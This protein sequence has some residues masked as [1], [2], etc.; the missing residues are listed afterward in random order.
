M[1]Q[2]TVPALLSALPIFV[3]A[4][5]LIPPDVLAQGG[6]E[7]KLAAESSLIG[8]IYKLVMAVFGTLVLW[9]GL[10]LN[11][12]VTH[13]VVGFGQL[14]TTSGLGITVDSLWVI[15]RD[16]FNLT[17]IFGLVLIGLKLIFNSDD[18]TTKKLLINLIIAAL[19]VNF[20][21]FI[22]KVV[23]DFSNI[24][25]VELVKAFPTTPVT[26]GGVATQNYDI[27]GSFV[28]LLGVQTLF[29]TRQTTDSSGASWAYVFMTMILFCIAAFVFAAGGILL[30][31]RFVVLNFCLILSPLMFLG[32]VF[33][34]LMSVSSK[35][36]HFFLS[37]AF[38]APV[39]I[40]MIYF[41]H[42]ILT[43][44]KAT[45]DAAGGGSANLST[46]FQNSAATT[47][48]ANVTASIYSAVIP[49]VL[50]SIFL[51]AAIVIS[52]KMG[53][54]GAT[55]AISMG[56]S[57]RARA[58]K[59][60]IGGSMYMGAK[61]AQNTV[62]WGARYALNSKLGSNFKSSAAKGGIIGT[63]AMA[64]VRATNATANASFDPRNVKALGLDKIG[65]AGVKGGYDN[66][67]KRKEK[68]FEERLKL[69]GE[70]DLDSDEGKEKLQTIANAD[71][72]T[73]DK[74]GN[75]IPQSNLN[76][77]VV[78]REAAEK[79]KKQIE[80]GQAALLKRQ[81]TISATFDEKISD[82]EKQLTE[83]QTNGM[84][85]TTQETL[86]AQI[87]E[88]KDA[89][90]ATL[91]PT[92]DQLTKTNAALNTAAH[93]LEK[94]ADAEKKETEKVKPSIQ[95]ERHLDYINSE[96]RAGEYWRSLS[97][98]VLSTGSGGIGGV[99]AAGAAGLGGG[100]ILAAGGVGAAGAFIAG[101]LYGSN[102]SAVA[103]KFM[104]DYGVDGS[105]KA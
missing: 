67:M 46:V 102:Q 89:R 2:C 25:T 49:F 64:T 41:A 65:G 61:T 10:I 28:N 72:T 1:R 105:K 87:Q 5:L 57:A 12:A 31:I 13:T 19:L 32:F 101:G 29:G 70:I 63:A 48:A 4:F 88:Q 23:V 58:Q 45:R 74:Q 50:T 30:I 11:Y 59:A 9:A 94:A 92:V 83:G 93:A 39:Y 81:E 84:D 52:Q 98:R 6:T 54:I 18:S 44:M 68:V 7:A 22:T 91:K 96:N 53:S 78:A 95:Y 71:G 56:K 33:P 76:K 69:L 86:K 37:Q 90:D 43:S 99:T 47:D 20:S 62:G 97:G 80:E 42:S 40:L 104:K 38:F 79:A 36:W 82:L 51:L 3:V 14:Y 75:L 77:A 85:L 15:M 24:A 35:Y 103:Q 8:I 55:Q 21:L 60:V 73:K 100:A 27:S 66:K 26:I 16:L 17:F 34:S